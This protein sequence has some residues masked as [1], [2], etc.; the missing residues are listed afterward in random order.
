[1]NVG[2]GREKGRDRAEP[3]AEARRLEERGYEV[4]LGQFLPFLGSQFP[5]VKLRGQ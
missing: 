2:Q 5:S 1:M 3:T 4:T